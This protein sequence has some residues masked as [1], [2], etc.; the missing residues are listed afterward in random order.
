LPPGYPEKI[1]FSF[2]KWVWYYPDRNKPKVLKAIEQHR[3]PDA[4]VLIFKNYESLER[5]LEQPSFYHQ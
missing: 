4:R 3:N 2:L 1:Y 5:F